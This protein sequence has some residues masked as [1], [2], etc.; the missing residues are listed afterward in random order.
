MDWTISTIYPYDK[1]PDGL[2]EPL[3]SELYQQG[4]Q[5]AES[6]TALHDA[7]DILGNYW[8]LE[9]LNQAMTV[10]VMVTYHGTPEHKG[11]AGH[12]NDALSVCVVVETYGEGASAPSTT[13]GSDTPPVRT[14]KT[15]RPTRDKNAGRR[16][17]S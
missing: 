11:I 6:R 14:T 1:D 2:Y 16:T 17:R 3:L 12:P 10:L 7:V 8:G 9:Y 13:T 5:D 4:Y 15:P